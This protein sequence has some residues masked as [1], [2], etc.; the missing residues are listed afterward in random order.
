MSK[1]ID[2]FHRADL[3]RPDRSLSASSRQVLSG[4]ATILLSALVASCSLFGNDPIPYEVFGE[5][6]TWVYRYTPAPDTTFTYGQFQ[7]PSTDTAMTY[8]ITCD[9]EKEFA[10]ASGRHVWQ[11][12]QISA[13]LVPGMYVTRRTE[14]LVSEVARGC[15]L[16][17]IDKRS[18]V[19]VPSDPA[20]RDQYQLLSCSGYAHEV[21][22]V[23][24]VGD[25]VTVPYGTFRTFTLSH[26]TTFHDSRHD[27]YV[28]FQEVWAVDFMPIRFDLLDQNSRLLGSF[29][30]V[31]PIE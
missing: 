6:S 9:E 17:E 5:S 18:F 23:Q 3:P 21:L 24:G 1:R 26:S 13:V 11:S 31:G 29:E 25:E 15:G 7:I 22:T 20:P 30:L 2:H 27:V 8:T 10:G 14:G 19:R 16:F 4:G 28:R 12:S